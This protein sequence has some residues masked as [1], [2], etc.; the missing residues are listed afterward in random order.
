VA[1]VQDV[2]GTLGGE[3]ARALG[4][5]PESGMKNH[6]RGDWP[7]F[8]QEGVFSDAARC[9]LTYEIAGVDHLSEA[10]RLAFVERIR[11]RI[12]MDELLLIFEK[13]RIHK[14][15]SRVTRLAAAQS[16]L[17]PGPALDRHVHRMW[18]GAVHQ[19]FREVEEARCPR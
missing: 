2:G 13:A 17:A 7:T 19:R 16:G 1:Y 8:S 14:M 10:G 15:D 3:K 4:G 11:G 12:G 6:P 5:V 18:A 9:T